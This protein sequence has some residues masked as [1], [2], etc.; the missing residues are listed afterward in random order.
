MFSI[1]TIKKLIFTC[2]NNDILRHTTWYASRT[3]ATN[4]NSIVM[5]FTRYRLNSFFSSF[6]SNK[7]FFVI[8]RACVVINNCLYSLSS[9]S[10]SDVG[11]EI[12]YRGESAI[13]ELEM[14]H[15]KKISDRTIWCWTLNIEMNKEPNLQ[16]IS[17]FWCK[18]CKFWYSKGK[19]WS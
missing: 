11:L 3:A 7:K 12:S 5:F 9:I 19:F 17:S 2:E 13:V 10:E 16:I 18:I 8:I 15:K 4:S 6:N 1:F 14:R